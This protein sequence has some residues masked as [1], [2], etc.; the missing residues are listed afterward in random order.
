MEAK[1]QRYPI[2]QQDF[3]KIREGNSVYVD[4][5]AIIYDLTHASDYVFLARPRRFGKSLLLSTIRYYFEGR[6]DLFEG[7]KIMD[8]EEK[9]T[10]H[11]VLH[12]MLSRIDKEDPDSLRSALEQQ[13]RIWEEDY[14]V[15]KND[16]AFSQRF[17]EII[18]HAAKKTGEK[19]VIL[20]DEYDNPLINTIDKTDIHENY[21]SLLK[22][23]Y[24]TMKDL[25]EYIRFAMITGVSRFS[26]TSIFSGLNNI[27]DI[28]F[29]SDFSSICGFTLE[30]IKEYLW[31]GVVGLGERRG[32]THEETLAALKDRYDG[33]HFTEDSPDIYNPFSLLNAL[34]KRDLG[35]YWIASGTP[36]FLVRKLSDSDIDFE[37]TFNGEGNEKTLGTIDV[38]YFSTEA[39]LYQTGYLTIKDYDPETGLFSLRIPNREVNYG[40]FSA[41][42]TD[43]ARKGEIA[44]LKTAMAL[45]KDLQ[46][47]RPKEFFDKLKSFLAGIPYDKL[48]HGFELNFE[49]VL[50]SMMRLL[51]LDVQSEAELSNGRI[52]LLVKTERYIYVIELKMDKPAK[53]ALA[54]IDSKDYA[55]PFAYDGRKLYKIGIEV[56]KETRNITDWLID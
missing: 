8:L 44:T 46:E 47:G 38:A 40:L 56:S 43:F 15:E 11:P 21:R 33:Y 3:A 2:G 18:R 49:K 30:D 55:L 16:M 7:L 5:T 12:L 24:S 17:S 51:D 27:N 29:D 42:L 22:S 1:K 19:V 54:Q 14:E 48:P 10:R 39:L 23:V 45:R 4:K 53:E 37:K 35:D 20:I 52:D 6:K 50:F 34:S 28:S 26:K 41:L 36:E 13:F 31:P 32:M 25:D 9:W